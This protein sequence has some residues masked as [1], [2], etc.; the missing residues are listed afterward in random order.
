MSGAIC[1]LCN[2][3]ARWHTRAHMDAPLMCLEWGCK[4][5]DCIVREEDTVDIEPNNILQFVP[6]DTS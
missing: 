6:R 1:L 2:H 5:D 4:C 3:P